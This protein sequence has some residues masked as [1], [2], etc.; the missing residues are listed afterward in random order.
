MSNMLKAVGGASAL[1]VSGVLLLSLSGCNFETLTAP[2]KPES[3]SQAAAIAVV[4]GVSL[5]DRD[6]MPLIAAGLDRANAIDRVINRAVAAGLAKQQYANEVQAAMSSAELEVAS[7]VY[8]TR[9]LEELLKQVSDADIESRYQ[10]SMKDAD[11]NGYQLS[12]ALYP[13]DEAARQGR[14]DAQQGK[15]DALQLYQPLASDKDGRALWVFRNDV[16]YNLGVFVAK[17]KE[18]E[19]TDPVVV[20]NGFVVLHLLKIKANAK[21]TLAE[22]K[23]QLRRAIADERLAQL[24]ADARKAAQVS[25]N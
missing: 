25:L 7:S 12:F 18:G 14:A 17:M 9:K 11:F 8:V 15:A 4:N 23:E 10:A 6:V 22:V 24:L 21:P 19:F 16:P 2:L 13:S 5:T 20:R 3:K 1:A